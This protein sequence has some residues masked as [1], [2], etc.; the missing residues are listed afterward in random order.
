VAYAADEQ[1][2]RAAHDALVAD[3]HDVAVT[4]M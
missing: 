2:L 3:G 4:A 1:A